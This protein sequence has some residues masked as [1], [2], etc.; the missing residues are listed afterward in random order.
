M[1]RYISPSSHFRIERCCCSVFQPVISRDVVVHQVQFLCFNHT[2]I[3]TLL[4]VIQQLF[5]SFLVSP[6]GYNCFAVMQ[7]QPVFEQSRLNYHSVFFLFF[8]FPRFTP[9]YPFVIFDLP[10]FM[11]T[12]SSHLSKVIDVIVFSSHRQ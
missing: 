7:L 4:K 2:V 11:G 9:C 3:F 12:R 1:M 10:P 6:S 5:L 8:P